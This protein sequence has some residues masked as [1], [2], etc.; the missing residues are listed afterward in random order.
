MVPTVEYRLNPK[1]HSLSAHWNHE[2][3]LI[4]AYYVRYDDGFQV[5]IPH[6]G[7][8]GTISEEPLDLEDEEQR[9]IVLGEADRVR[10]QVL[11]ERTK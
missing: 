9:A 2:H 5:A 3:V 6:G 4:G 8:L 7:C 1:E 11:E 10:A